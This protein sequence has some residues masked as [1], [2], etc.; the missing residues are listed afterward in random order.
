[1]NLLRYVEKERRGGSSSLSST[2]ESEVRSTKKPSYLV[3]KVK[4][5]CTV[6]WRRKE[7]LE[8]WKEDRGGGGREDDH[9]EDPGVSEGG[10]RIGGER[11]ED[12]RGIGGWRKDLREKGGREDDQREEDWKEEGRKKEGRKEGGGR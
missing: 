12:R 5:V 2:S 1:M 8:D 7:D 11:K 10:E 3:I 4:V 9:R 6:G